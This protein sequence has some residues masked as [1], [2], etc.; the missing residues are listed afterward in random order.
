MFNVTIGRYNAKRNESVRDAALIKDYYSRLKPE[1]VEK[2][3]YLYERDMKL[4][5]YTF[6]L[7]TLEAGGFQTWTTLV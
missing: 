1:T 5:G 7:K 4:F 2:I 3:Y 6:N